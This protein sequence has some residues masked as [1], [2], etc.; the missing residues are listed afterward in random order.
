MPGLNT[1]HFFAPESSEMCESNDIS[2]MKFHS[3]YFTISHRVIFHVSY[4]A[5][6]LN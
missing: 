2:F 1:V 4:L 3:Q 6:F 5:I